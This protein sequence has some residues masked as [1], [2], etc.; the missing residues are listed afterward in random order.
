MSA[1]LD[2]YADI[3][4]RLARMAIYFHDGIFNEMPETAA[5]CTLLDA[6]A[7]KAQ[8][9]RRSINSYVAKVAA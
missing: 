6:K 1:A 7:Y 4:S 2:G 8:M 9:D 3:S 5:E